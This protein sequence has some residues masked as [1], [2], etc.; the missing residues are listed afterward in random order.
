L[1]EK[2]SK[3]LKIFEVLKILNLPLNISLIRV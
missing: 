1:K 2:T 3:L